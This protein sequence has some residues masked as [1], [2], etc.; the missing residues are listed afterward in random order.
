MPFQSSNSPPI[1]A[2]RW[3]SAEFLHIIAILAS[4]RSNLYKFTE[5][6]YN[7]KINTKGQF[8]FLRGKLHEVTMKSFARKAQKKGPHL[9]SP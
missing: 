8:Y 9:S 1:S 2:C 7:T 5:T 4:P 6:Y 3:A